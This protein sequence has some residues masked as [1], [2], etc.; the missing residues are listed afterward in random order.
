MADRL[1]LNRYN[2]DGKVNVK[3]SISSSLA[4]LKDTFFIAAQG[5]VNE[6]VLS[7]PI[8]FLLSCMAI[9]SIEG[10]Y[11]ESTRINSN[12]GIVVLRDRFGTDDYLMSILVEE[13][14]N[15]EEFK[16]HDA[17]DWAID[18][19]ACEVIDIEMAPDTSPLFSE[20]DDF[21]LYIDNS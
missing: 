13:F 10:T 21:R 14:G 18:Q 17:I 7:M 3:T 19:S 11:I 9:T 1:Q 16:F 6:P 15:G 12:N 4:E 5:I 20:Q 8:E 2:N